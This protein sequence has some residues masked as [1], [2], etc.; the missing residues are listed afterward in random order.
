MTDEPAP[1]DPKK[2]DLRFTDR[3]DHGVSI[4]RDMSG[5]G[6]LARGDHTHMSSLKFSMQAKSRD[7]LDPELQALHPDPSALKPRHVREAEALQA[8]E[9]P[10]PPPAVAVNAEEVAPTESSSIFGRVTGGLRRWMAGH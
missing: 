6:R 8:N 4:D 5:S 7:Y 2:K 1:A 9:A 10:A 3:V